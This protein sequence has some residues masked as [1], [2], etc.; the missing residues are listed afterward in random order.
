MKTEGIVIKNSKGKKLAGLI[1]G[2]NGSKIVIATHGISGEKT[3][4]GRFTKLAKAL[5]DVNLDTLLFDFSGSGES[6]DEFI[7]ITTLT[8]DANSVIRYCYEKGYSEINLVGFSFGALS[9]LK[10]YK[11]IP[12][13]VN[14]IVLWAP[15]TSAYVDLNAS[16]KIIPKPKINDHVS[17][18]VDYPD[19]DR[20]FISKA[21]PAENS[22]IDREELL[23]EIKQPVLIIHGGVDEYVSVKNSEEAMKYL[24]EGSR[25][26]I[27]KDAN[28]TFTDYDSQIIKLTIDWIQK[29]TS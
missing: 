11:N 16:D 19:R 18:P 27:I 10:A 17:R 7:S 20:I 21:F 5:D 26:E 25:L 23:S 15:I 4:H 22:S 6:E 28:H 29:K 9:I 24:P 14:N 13:E 1:Q 3:E 2:S 8:D 12:I